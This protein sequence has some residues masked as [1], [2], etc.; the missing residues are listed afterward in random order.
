MTG[1]EKMDLPR[2]ASNHRSHQSHP[3]SLPGQAG[4]LRGAL[5]AS[6]NLRFGRLAWVRK[7]EEG[8]RGA[9]HHGWF[10]REG[11]I[12]RE[13]VEAGNPIQRTTQHYSSS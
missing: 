8:L 3:T 1:Q 12:P 13:L 9:M 2:I 10:V 4:A 7:M 11:G 6:M 5:G